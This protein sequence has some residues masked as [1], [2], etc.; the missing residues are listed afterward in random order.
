MGQ[1]HD[2]PGYTLPKKDQQVLKIMCASVFE[3]HSGVQNWVS[4]QSTKM[5]G[6][7]MN[8]ACEDSVRLKH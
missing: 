6:R 3:R 4:G 5:Q 2:D 8:G 7:V 1:I